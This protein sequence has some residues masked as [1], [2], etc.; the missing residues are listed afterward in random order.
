MTDQNIASYLNVS[1][2]EWEHRLC[3]YTITVLESLKLGYTP[4]MHFIEEQGE[5]RENRRT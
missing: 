2:E 4:K 3:V 1:T 5:K